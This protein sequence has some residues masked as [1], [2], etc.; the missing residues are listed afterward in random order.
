MR[1]TRSR[2]A[3][4]AARVER[5]KILVAV[6]QDVECNERDAAGRRRAVRSGQVNAILQALK[7]GGFAVFVERDD[8]AVEHDRAVSAFSRNG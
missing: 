6:A 4:R 2:R 8:L 7:A 3:R 5:P 1:N